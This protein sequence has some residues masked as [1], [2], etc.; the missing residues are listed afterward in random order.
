MH[1]YIP[2]FD[3]TSIDDQRE[4]LKLYGMENVDTMTDMQTNRAFK[5]RIRRETS[6]LEQDIEGG[7]RG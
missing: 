7:S 6:D 4:L 3:T 1:Q 2:N 5:R